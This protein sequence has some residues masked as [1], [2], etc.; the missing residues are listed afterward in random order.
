L[1]TSEKEMIKKELKELLDNKLSTVKYNY[2]FY[3]KCF[4]ELELKNEF[5]NKSPEPS[6]FF[7]YLDT[8]ERYVC[9]YFFKK[10]I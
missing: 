4:T 10:N 5:N 6:D 1:N 2:Y 3:F 9:D 7:M 8:Q